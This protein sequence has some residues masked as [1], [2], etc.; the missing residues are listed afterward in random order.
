M[1]SD[2]FC[3]GLSQVVRAAAAAALAGEAAALQVAQAMTTATAAGAA[4]AEGAASAPALATSPPEEASRRGKQGQA[5]SFVYPGQ[6]NTS[7]ENGI[8][9]ELRSSSFT[10]RRCRIDAP[11]PRFLHPAADTMLLH[12]RG[13]YSNH[14]T[15]DCQTWLGV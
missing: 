8:S 14:H 11:F 3:C 7:Q 1:P 9:A 5:S 15:A 12:E 6:G 13:L 4:A 2:A 10:S